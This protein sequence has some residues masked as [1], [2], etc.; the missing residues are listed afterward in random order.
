MLPGLAR[1]R[2]RRRLERQLG[3]R[4]RS[5]ALV[6]A[7]G[8][9][10]GT[11]GRQTAIPVGG[12]IGALAVPVVAEARAGLTQR[13]SSSRRCRSPALSPASPAQAARARRGRRGDVGPAD[14]GGCEALAAE[15][16]QRCLPLRPDGGDRVHG[17]LPPRRARLVRR[18]R[19]TSGR[20]LPAARRRV[21]YRGG[22][23]V[24]EGRLAHRAPPPDRARRRR[25]P[26]V[27]GRSRGWPALAPRGRARARRRAV[28]GL[29]RTLVHGWRRSS[30]APGGAAL[31]LASSRPCSQASASAA[32]LLF[33]ASVSVGSWELAFAL[34]AVFPV[35]GSVVLRP[36]R[37]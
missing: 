9:R 16:R 30:P 14:A 2:R 25:E 34:A 5:H 32:P 28:D 13:S 37:G 1:A 26:G 27:G 36:L 18:R 23:L 11:R 35:A 8:T 29:E 6:R 21:A 19:R 33:A 12:L 22:P 17:R 10:P 20:G 31:P 15:P 24:L 3:E 4:S 7:G